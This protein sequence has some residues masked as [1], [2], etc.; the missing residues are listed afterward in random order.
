MYKLGNSVN[1]IYHGIIMVCQIFGKLV[2]EILDTLHM[3]KFTMTDIIMN[4]KSQ[5]SGIREKLKMAGQK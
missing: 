4:W 1:D 3:P 2:R 5:N